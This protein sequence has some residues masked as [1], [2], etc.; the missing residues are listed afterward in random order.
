MWEGWSDGPAKWS[1]VGPCAPA[2]LCSCGAHRRIYHQLLI[3]KMRRNLIRG[4]GG[5]MLL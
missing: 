1:P 4:F 3:M 5:L 2:V